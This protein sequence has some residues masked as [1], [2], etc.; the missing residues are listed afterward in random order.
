MLERFWMFWVIAFLIFAVTEG[1]CKERPSTKRPHI[2]AVKFNLPP[3][4]DG[5]LDDEV[6]REAAKVTG[7]GRTDK[8]ELAEEQ[9]E[10]MI[11]Y[12][13]FA[14]YIAFLCYDSQLHPICA[15][16]RKRSGGLE[17]DDSFGVVID[18]LNQPRVYGDTNY[19]FTVNPLGTQDEWYRAV[20]LSR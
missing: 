20:W 11:C 1:W 15:Q 2:P 4:I 9:T 14:I 8:D 12:D 3:K 13:D 17:N 5:I 7:F 16:Q 18:S 10:V 6:W 19:T